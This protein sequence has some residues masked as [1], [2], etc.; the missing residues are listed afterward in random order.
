MQRSALFL[1]SIHCCRQTAMVV[2]LVCGAGRCTPL[3]AQSLPPFPNSE[4]P[5]SSPADARV[6][7]STWTRSDS[8]DQRANVQP[9]VFSSSSGSNVATAS[10]LRPVESPRAL[11]TVD[12]APA[13]SGSL[14]R[15]E[16]P[17]K[18]SQQT[19]SKGSGPARMIFS[20]GSSLL[21]V[22]G[23]IV[24]CAWLYRKSVGGAARSGLP[25]NVV[26]LL[27]RTPVAPRQHLVL[28]RFGSKL[29]LVSMVQGETRAISEITD[30]LEVDRL[31]G[32]C[33]SNRSG[34][35][36]ASF[37]DILTHGGRA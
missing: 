11:P 8:Y 20:M 37:R 1:K 34:S 25:D 23:L 6:Q 4:P 21:I 19:Q 14:T 30:P 28:L 2:I 31:A 9:S 32:L 22:L 36:T 35:M 18:A 5:I 12:S 24:G 27:G 10:A 16:P 13:G 29:V 7:D 3:S 17:S 33:E 26:Q 15:L